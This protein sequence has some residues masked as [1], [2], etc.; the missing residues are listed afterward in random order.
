MGTPHQSAREGLF[1]PEDPPKQLDKFGNYNNKIQA[2]PEQ[3]APEEKPVEYG[4]YNRRIKAWPE[5]EP[6]PPKPHVEYTDFNRKSKGWSEQ[7]AQQQQ[8]HQRQYQQQQ[9][10]PQVSV[11]SDNTSPHSN[12][13]PGQSLSSFKSSHQVT[14]VPKSYYSLPRGFGKSQMFKQKLPPHEL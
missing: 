5:K 11:S 1:D 4:D 10:P 3:E 8:H 6:E 9:T 7:S 13:W 12:A 14:S 2:W